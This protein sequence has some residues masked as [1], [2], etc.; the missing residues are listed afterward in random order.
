M[1]IEYSD[2]ALVDLLHIEEYY[3]ERA[4]PELALTM[5][6]RIKSTL[7]LLLARNPKVGRRRPDISNDARSLPV[8]PYIVFYRIAARRIVVLRILHGHRD[9][10]PPLA[11][12]LMAV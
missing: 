11:S 6:R 9:I 8:L 10:R 12:L 3:A 1:R 5:R 7:E 4:G 2:P